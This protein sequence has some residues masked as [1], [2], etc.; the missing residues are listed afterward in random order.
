M[1]NETCT[2]CGGGPVTVY[3]KH[4]APFC[5]QDCQKGY[6]DSIL[7]FDLAELARDMDEVTKPTRF[8]IP[9]S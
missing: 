7:E 1:D 3:G 8:L 6:W 2:F 5:N 4:L 9:S